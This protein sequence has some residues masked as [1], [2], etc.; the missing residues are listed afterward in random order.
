[1]ALRRLAGGASGHRHRLAR[2]SR[3]DLVLV[4]LMI[5]AVPAGGHARHV[6]DRPLRRR[7]GRPRPISMTDFAF[8]G[9]DAFASAARSPRQAKPR[10]G[11]STALLTAR[12]AGGSGAPMLVKAWH[13]T[14]G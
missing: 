12:P 10:A 5:T 13:V 1:M 4:I 7:Y 9:I 11:V 14:R 2:S 3:V 8:S 6:I